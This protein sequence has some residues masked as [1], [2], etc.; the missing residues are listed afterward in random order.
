[1]EKKILKNYGHDNV[2][3]SSN[4]NIIFSLLLYTT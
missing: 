3:I 1:M 4:F 2:S